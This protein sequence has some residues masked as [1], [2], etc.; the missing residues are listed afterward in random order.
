M[1]R[2]LGSLAFNVAYV[3]WTTVILLS[4]WVLLPFPRA[5]MQRGVRLWGEGT[6]FALRHL[7]GIRHEIRGLQHRLPGP[8][9]FASK[10]QSAWETMIFHALLP[11]P[12]FVLKKELT[13]IPFW[14]LYAR[15][16]TTIVVDRDA[17]ASAVKVLVRG[18]KVALA[19][20]RPVVIFPEGT[21]SAPG[22]RRPYFP[23]VAGVYTQCGMTVVP[24]AVN[25]GT[26]WGRNAFLKRPGT[27]VLEFLPAIA[28]GLDRRTFLHE[29][30]ERIETATLRLEEEA[31]LTPCGC[32]CPQAVQDGDKRD[33]M[34][35]LQPLRKA[36]GGDGRVETK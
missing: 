35:V 3:A 19:E 11:D 8:V 26:Y 16:N 2:F 9:L 4:L 31:A 36:A 18:A 25:S 33:E 20:G 10:H 5:A 34:A 32:S 12:V 7:L 29:L 15:K 13:R 21:R 27:I 28:P 23:G 1:R 24:V 6:R 30:E 22:T 17:G 14:G